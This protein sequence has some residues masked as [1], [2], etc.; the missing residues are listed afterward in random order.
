MI[1]GLYENIQRAIMNDAQIL[2][3]MD[4]S[5]ADPVTIIKRIEKRMKPQNLVEQNLPLISFY[6]VQGGGLQRSNDRVYDAIFMFDVYTHDDV[7]QAFDISARLGDM[8][9]GFIPE[10]DSVENFETLMISQFESEADLANT[11][12]FSTALK[13][14]I[15]VDR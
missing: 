7:S 9:H 12:C 13:F 1:T 10:F 15:T 14:S 8:F 2:E 11:F 4:L 6:A 5:A 3:L